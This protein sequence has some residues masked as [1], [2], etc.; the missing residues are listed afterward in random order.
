M[1]KTK[2]AFVSGIEETLSG[3]EKYKK[4]QEKKKLK[5]G[6]KQLEGLGLKGGERIKVIEG[7]IPA[8]IEAKKKKK[9]KK[10]K[11]RG[12]KYIKSKT[13]F[14]TSE[15][16]KI[17]EAIGIVKETSYSKFDGT[18]EGHFTVKKTGLS[19]NV[20]LPHSTG[21]L[22]KIEVASNKTIEN[23]SKGKID[24]DVLLATPEM[25]PKLVP[26]AKTLGPKGLMPNPKNGTLIRKEEDAKKFS[27]DTLTIK[28]EKDFPLVHTSFGKV[29][30][31]AKLLEENLKSII[32][33]IGPKQIVKACIKAT[34]SPSVKI[35]I[36]A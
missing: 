12:K 23:L 25:M 4:K 5:E 21:K 31:D 16:Y 22:K 6:K 33:A 24:F 34:M 20:T 3:K 14:D 32:D 30:M 27:A 7:E 19:V 36:P 18:V 13:K 15:E 11:A 2:T 26:F 1:G 28:T 9:R 8:E 35:Q 29:S 10:A 17:P